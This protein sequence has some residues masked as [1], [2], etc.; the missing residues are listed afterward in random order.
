GSQSR[1]SKEGAFGLLSPCQYT[2]RKPTCHLELDIAK[3]V[4]PLPIACHGIALLLLWALL[5]GLL[6]L[7][8]VGALLTAALTAAGELE[9]G[10][11]HVVGVADDALVGGVFA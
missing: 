1:P 3:V 11:R 9:V 8:L 10:H 7:L 5:R 4:R 6:L 2:P